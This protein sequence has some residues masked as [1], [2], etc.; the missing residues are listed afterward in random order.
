MMSSICAWERSSDVL[1]APKTPD[2]KGSSGCREQTFRMASLINDVDGRARVAV[3][4]LPAPG[5]PSN[6]FAMVIQ[7]HVACSFVYAADLRVAVQLLDRVILREAYAAE[8]LD[9]L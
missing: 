5:Y 3:S 2:R 7:L 8:D 6:C 4:G 1:A 9:R